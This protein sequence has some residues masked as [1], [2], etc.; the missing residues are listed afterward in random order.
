MVRIPKDGHSIR[1]G[2]EGSVVLRGMTTR[3]VILSSPVGS[4]MNLFGE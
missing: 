1:L 3:R 2:A 4:L